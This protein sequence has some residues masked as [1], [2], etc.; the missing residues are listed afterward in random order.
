MTT[1]HIPRLQIIV[2][3]TGYKGSGKDEAA[4]VLVKQFGFTQYAFADA[5]R[6]LAL[7]INPTLDLTHVDPAVAAMLRERAEVPGIVRYHDAVRL[8]TYDAAKQ[9]P[10][11]RRFL[12]RLGTEGIRYM[13]GADAW[14]TALELRIQCEAQ[15]ATTPLRAVI[16]DLRF[17]NECDWI[18]SF[19]NHRTWRII[20][21]GAESDGHAS[22][23]DISHLPVTCTILNNAS[24]KSYQ[25]SV[26]DLARQLSF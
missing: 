1:P 2:G 7:R 3:V 10:D 4:R 6:E 23:K 8:I 21:P 26:A 5:L 24:F 25:R 13:F 17:F 15:A 18:Q 14:I 22:E 16:S 12:Q 11:A 9:I 19:P 20:R